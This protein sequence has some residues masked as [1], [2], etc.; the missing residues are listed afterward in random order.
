M[1]KNGISMNSLWSKFKRLITRYKILD[2]WKYRY[3]PNSE[4]NLYFKLSPLEKEK[5][6][7][8]Y[9]E[10]GII[11]YTFYPCGGIGWGVK[12]KVWK[13]NEYI[14]ITDVNCW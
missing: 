4:A 9:K 6:N 10:K 14:D 2:T 7:R 12:V 3:Y 13:T 8:I 1:T 5:A 11:E